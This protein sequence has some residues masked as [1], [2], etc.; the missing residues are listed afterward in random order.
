MGRAIDMEKDI[1]MLKAQVKSLED[2]VRGMT[3]TMDGLSEKSSTTEH[4]DL[5][6]DVKL[7]EGKDGKKANNKTSSKSA[8]TSS[9]STRGSKDANNKSRNT[10]K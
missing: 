1:D 7:E 3:H 10:S 5:V 4:I 9:S 2:I 8:G 6:D